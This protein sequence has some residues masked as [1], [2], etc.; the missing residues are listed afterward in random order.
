[1]QAALTFVCLA[2]RAASALSSH[3]KRAVCFWPTFSAGNPA[4]NSSKLFN[5]F[6]DWIGSCCS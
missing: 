4:K 5:L 2:E 3:S 1:M 6:P